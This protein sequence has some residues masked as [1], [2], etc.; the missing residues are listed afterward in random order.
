MACRALIFDFDGVVADSETLACGVAAVYATELGAP[1]TSAEGLANFVG[2]RVADV[3]S[4]ITERGG[5]VPEDFADQLHRRTLAGF[6]ERLE[7][8]AG[9][10]AFLEAHHFLPRCIASSSSHAR[11]DASLAR[12][13][14][15]HWFDG[16]IYSADDVARGK[17]FPDL[18]L[19][20]ARML[21]CA[22]ADALVI[23]DSSSGVTAAVAAGMPVI[24]L[25]AGSHVGADHGAKLLA[26]GASAIA[27]DYE[28]V[29][30]WMGR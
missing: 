30:A 24:G 20:A 10:E 19:H 8:V 2:K 18:F 28:T 11:L 3:A 15:S 26:A 17:P 14:L 1:M 5:V 13:G 6:S 29:S 4:L 23:E 16:H 27:E 9:V 22:P 7:P 21:G 12:L 25:L